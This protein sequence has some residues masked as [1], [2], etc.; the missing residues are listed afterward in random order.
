MFN[1]AQIFTQKGYISLQQA[2]NSA[3][4]ETLEKANNE[5]YAHRAVT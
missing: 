4:I 1:D 5:L 2:L 3:D